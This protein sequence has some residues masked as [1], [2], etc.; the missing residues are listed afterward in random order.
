LSDQTLPG[1]TKDDPPREPRN[2]YGDELELLSPDVK[3]TEESNIGAKRRCGWGATVWRRLRRR[4]TAELRRLLP[5]HSHST[6]RAGEM[7]A[8]RDPMLVVPK[9][10]CRKLESVL[11]R[12]LRTGFRADS[13]TF[14]P[15][16][17]GRQQRWPK[18]AGGCA[19]KQVQA[20][21]LYDRATCNPSFSSRTSSVF[22]TDDD[23]LS[24]I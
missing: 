19:G 7:L 9:S 17:K 21:I 13:E 22:D 23:G 1:L 20:K 4:E 14:R 18:G 16:Y 6:G 10:G 12:R 3:H 2:G 8:S 11:R 5:P 24:M 15:A